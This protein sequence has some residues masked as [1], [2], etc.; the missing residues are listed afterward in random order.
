MKASIFQLSDELWYE[1]VGF[2]NIRPATCSV[3]PRYALSLHVIYIYTY[4]YIIVYG[5]S[6]WYMLCVQMCVGGVPE[7]IKKTFENHLKINK[8]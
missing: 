3:P 2:R 7:T 4:I 5:I 1:L 8:T 6:I